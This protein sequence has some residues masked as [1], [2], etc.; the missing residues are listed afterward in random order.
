MIDEKLTPFITKLEKSQ[1]FCEKMQTSLEKRIHEF[2]ML[3]KENKQNGI[4]KTQMERKINDVEQM[5]SEMNRQKIE[6]SQSKENAERKTTE[7]ILSLNK[8]NELVKNIFTLLTIE[9]HR[10][11]M[12]ISHVLVAGENKKIR[13][14][15]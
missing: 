13:G 2:H 3:K 6:L 15:K 12:L 7:I 11:S 1:R 5:S 8:E 4:R 14:G 10:Q 9:I